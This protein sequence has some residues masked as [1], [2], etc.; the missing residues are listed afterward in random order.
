MRPTTCFRDRL[1]TSCAVACLVAAAAALP[2]PEARGQ[3]PG[4][5]IFRKDLKDP[6]ELWD[7]ADYL[8]RTGQA[9]QAVPYLN[10]FLKSKPDDATLLAIRD[11]YGVRSILRLQDDP[12]TR[13][14]AAPVTEMLNAAARRNA[15]RPERI[16]RFVAALTKS[17]EEQ[18]YAVERL[19][20]AGPYAVPFL[21]EA[22][23]RP[24]L[25]AEDRALIVGNVGRLDSSTVPPL[26]AA[27]DSPDATVVRDV[28]DAL[29]QIGDRRAVPRLTVLAARN[30]P[31]SALGAA[32]R[33]AILRLTG[34][35][36]ESQPRSPVRVLT[37]EA[38]RYHL[39]ALRFPGDPVLIWEWDQERKE[40]APRQVSRS[41]AE[42]VFG[43]RAAREAL[44]LDPTDLPAQVVLVSLA[45]DK[46]VERAG[47][48][49]FPANDPGGAF[50]A[51]LAAGPVVL[52]EVLRTAIAD[53]K[54]DLAAVAATALG[55]ETDAN[56]LPEGRRVNP[57]VEALSA[58]S[59]RVQF[60]AARALVLLDPRKPF[61]GSSRVVPVL[62]WFVSGQAHPRAVVID[63]NPT[64]G[65]R[66]AGYLKALGY[67]PILA[68]TGDEGFRA[69]ADS[70]DVELVLVDNHLIQGDW[71]V[72]DTLSNLRADARTAG[73]PV[74]VVGPLNLNEQLADLAVRFPGLRFIVQPTSAEILERQLGGR[75]MGLSAEERAGYARE[76]ALLLGKIAAEPGSPFESDL[77]RAGPALTVALN[78]PATGLAASA[79][80]GDVPDPGAQRGLADA[81]I[82]PSKPAPLRLSAAGQLAKSIQ[83][84]GR[85][86]SAGQEVQLAQAYDRERDPA[87][88]AALATVLGALRP[89]A[90]LVGQRLQRYQPLPP[91]PA[92]APQ[93]TGAAPSP[94]APA[95][96]PPAEPAPPPL[97]EGAN[98]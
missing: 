96:T 41:E 70:A 37:D 66:L 75:P 83:R 85:L 65:S 31:K 47:Y 54:T 18:A 20:E 56:A 5:E 71:R 82:D 51:A 52:G 97:A 74:F 22:L 64:R 6:M 45:L 9:K 13:P 19:K 76:A 30:A 11:R 79:A 34:K 81:L 61:A 27:L 46:A 42:E 57:L 16:A 7:A 3:A 44:A 15:T 40:P 35:P 17:K 80:L 49:A 48:T 55:Q 1:A 59:R 14:L 8:V 94:P 89:K 38:R 95:G 78:A 43:L 29:G 67:D 4:P 88:R 69:A 12:A 87:L 93:P 90:G 60:A 92:Q 10:Q 68:T 25:P 26:I 62:A 86:V 58:P 28:A 2:A 24:G 50:P 77:A 36:F 84:F 39:H 21:I 23:G 63:G 98:P 72:V 33:Q 91:P 73:I 53:G 32:A